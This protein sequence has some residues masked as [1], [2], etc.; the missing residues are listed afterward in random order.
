MFRFLKKTISVSFVDDQTGV[1]FAS[2]ELPPDQ[3]PDTFALETDL[4]MRGNHYVVVAADPPN[5]EAFA[6]SKRLTVR[7]QRVEQMD[8]RAVLF[9]M[10]SICSS[11]LPACERVESSAGVPVL[12]EDDWRQCELVSATHA[13]DISAEL[14]AIREVHAK[15]WTGSGW[16]EVHA[17]QRIPKPMPEGITWSEVTSL[18]N[19]AIIPVPSVAFQPSGWTGSGPSAGAV[20]A[21]VNAVAGSFDDGVLLWG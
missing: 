1:T 20:D 21:V 6:K 18:L 14:A 16:R 3:L 5:K 11:A 8:P 7:L 2:S 19:R 9:S 15:A 12:H 4:D 17:R 13:S 10:P